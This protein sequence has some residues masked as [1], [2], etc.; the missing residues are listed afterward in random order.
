MLAQCSRPVAVESRAISV[1]AQTG[2][3]CSALIC[4]TWWVN[5]SVQRTWSWASTPE[6]VEQRR[7][8]AQRLVGTELAAVHYYDIDY[9]RHDVAPDHTGSWEI[10]DDSEWQQPSWAYP[11]CDSIDFGVEFMTAAGETYSVTWDPPG[12]REGIGI[13]QTPLL[14]SALLPDGQ[15]AVWS[16]GDRSRWS[17]LIGERITGVDLHYLPWLHEVEGSPKDGFWCTRITITF[18]DVRAVL[19]L[20]EGKEGGGV[21]P[22]A[23][24]VAVLFEPIVLP[25]WEDR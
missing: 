22:S 4:E 8:E 1:P 10:L 23:D 24:T 18:G 5:E 17:D 11:D 25:D 2:R 16:V 19:T 21:A 3:A 12:D 20:G 14:G 9:F 6:M 15:F 7:V 13:Q